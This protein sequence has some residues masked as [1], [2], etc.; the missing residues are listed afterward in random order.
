[1]ITHTK[2]CF[3]LIDNKSLQGISDVDTDDSKVEVCQPTE[4]TV[5]AGN[6]ESKPGDPVSKSEG[7]NKQYTHKVVSNP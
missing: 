4:D 5:I 6:P 3:G 7:K 1:M 2:H